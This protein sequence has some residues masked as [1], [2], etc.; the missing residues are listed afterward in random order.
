[1]NCDRRE[2]Y[3]FYVSVMNDLVKS[4]TSFFLFI[5]RNHEASSAPEKKKFFK[6]I[7]LKAMKII[8]LKKFFWH[9]FNNIN[10]ARKKIFP[11]ESL[12]KKLVLYIYI[13][14]V[15]KIVRM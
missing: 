5:N 13:I 9:H 3:G 14:I 15:T 12:A 11:M 8:P 10:S 6:N 1:M 7:N 2:I 4:L